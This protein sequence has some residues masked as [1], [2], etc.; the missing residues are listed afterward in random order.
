MTAYLLV[1]TKIADAEGYEA[2]KARAKPIVEEHGGR[3]LA[4][5]GALDI[6]EDDLWRPTRLVLIEFPSMDAAR[7]FLNSEPYRPVKALR[8]ANADCTVVLLEGL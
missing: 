5:G 1:D 3:Y 8:H 7:G 6:R 2:Y 4:R